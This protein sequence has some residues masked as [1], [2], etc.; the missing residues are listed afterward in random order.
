[1]VYTREHEEKH[2]YKH[3]RIVYTREHETLPILDNI[4]LKTASRGVY[5]CFS[6]KIKFS[7]LKG[8]VPIIFL[9]KIR[10]FCSLRSIKTLTS[11]SPL[12]FH[13]LLKLLVSNSIYFL[14][15]LLPIVLDPYTWF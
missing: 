10:P 3:N 9:S 12:R 8:C 15:P 1:M 6:Y 13:G 11:I 2:K 4:L 5:A 7:L 14:D